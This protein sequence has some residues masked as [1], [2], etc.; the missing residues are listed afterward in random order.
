MTEVGVF[1]TDL[2]ELLTAPSQFLVNVVGRHHGAI[3]EPH[4]F[5]VQWH[6]GT[7]SFWCSHNCISS[8]LRLLIT[9]LKVLAIFFV[10]V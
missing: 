5:P 10:T 6:R 1:N 4:F 9:E 7:Y 8:F 3:G 2:L